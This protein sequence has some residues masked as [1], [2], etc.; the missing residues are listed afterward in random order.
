MTEQ[1]EAGPHEGPVSGPFDAL[2]KVFDGAVEKSDDID[3][4][5]SSSAWILS[6]YEAFHASHPAE[7]TPVD[8]GFLALTRGEAP[9]LGRFLA[10]FE[11]MW[12]LACPLVGPQPKR[13]GKEAGQLLLTRDDWQVLWL[14]GLKRDSARFRGLVEGLA[15]RCELR[16]GPESLRYRASLEG[17]FDG[18]LGRR[19][20]RF[21]KMIRQLM[22]R[23][24]SLRFEWIDSQTPLTAEEATA[25]YERI[26]AVETRSWKGLEG[27][28]FVTGDMKRFY[29]AMVPR[30]ARPHG[31]GHRL[32]VLFAKDGAED[33][34]VCFGGVFGDT[35]RGLQ[36]SFDDRY[37]ELGLGNRMQ[38]E[39][40]SRLATEGVGIYDLGSEMDYKARWAEGRDTSL[41]LIGVRR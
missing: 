41:T 37:R 1:A 24:D 34:A 33:V 23:G 3:R 6:A 36:N 28:G 8:E 22:R 14:G 18:W 25:L 5:C 21:R 16:L 7:I 11:A 20:P 4:F 9:G 38:A 29:G 10:A 26:H 17:G 35:F 32:R 40:I 31:L 12:G 13:L 15:K 30:L 19:S 2:A 39:V 27:T